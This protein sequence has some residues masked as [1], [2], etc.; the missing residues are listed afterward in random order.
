MGRNFLLL[1]IIFF[2]HHLLFGFIV[3]REMVC[4]VNDHAL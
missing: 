3:L 4:D 1:S 2:L